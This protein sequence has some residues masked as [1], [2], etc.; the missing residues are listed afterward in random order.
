MSNSCNITAIQVLQGTGNRT[1]TAIAIVKAL[2]LATNL[3]RQRVPQQYNKL[4][5]MHKPHQ[6][7]INKL[8]GRYISNI[9]HLQDPVTIW[10]KPTT[11]VASINK[12]G[13]FL[14]KYSNNRNFKGMDKY[15]SFCVLFYRWF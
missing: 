3:D 13:V 10:L 11:L 2:P 1:P 5:G 9:K 6:I 14:G 4:L 7:H 15:L 12:L 8:I